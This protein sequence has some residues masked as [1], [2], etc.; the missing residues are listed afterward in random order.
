MMQCVQHGHVI[1]ALANLKPSNGG[2][3]VFINVIGCTIPFFEKIM[4]RFSEDDITSIFM[5]KCAE[6]TE[7]DFQCLICHCA[8]LGRAGSDLHIPLS[9]SSHSLC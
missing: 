2:R 8:I 1:V 5:E 3:D 4:G 9:Q 6:K 7:C